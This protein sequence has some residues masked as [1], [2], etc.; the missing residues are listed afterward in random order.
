MVLKAKLYGHDVGV[1][2][3]TNGG[4]FF[5]YFDDFI[6]SGFDTKGIDFAYLK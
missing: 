3:N 1:L 5:Q 6:Q 4:Y 2:S